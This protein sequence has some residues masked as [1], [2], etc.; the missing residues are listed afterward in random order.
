MHRH[1]LGSIQADAWPVIAHDHRASLEQI[2]VESR[3]PAGNGQIHLSPQQ[4]LYVQSRLALI[5]I[6]CL[7]HEDQHFAGVVTDHAPNPAEHTMR[8]CGARVWPVG[9]VTA[10]QPPAVDEVIV[11]SRHP[12]GDGEI[13]LSPDQ[14]DF[15]AKQ[16][17]HIALQ[18]LHDD[19]WGGEDARQQ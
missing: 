8:E 17:T 3:H 1:Y 11:E 19:V 14:A 7:H 2:I 16:L 6:G 5:A 15:V 9:L 12:D 4:A 18:Y 13:H 10:S